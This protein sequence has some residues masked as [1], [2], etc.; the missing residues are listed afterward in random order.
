MGGTS[1][2][3]TAP[4]SVCNI[5]GHPELNRQVNEVIAVKGD[6]VSNCYEAISEGDI[7]LSYAQ[8]RLWFLDQLE[9]GRSTYNIPVAV[10]LQGHL[11]VE[12]LGRALLE[13]IRRHEVLRTHI[14]LRGGRGVQV[15]EAQWSG[16]VEEQD[17]RGLPAVERSQEI[18]RVA[19]EEAERPFDLSRG[20]LLRMRLLYVEEQEHVLLLTMHHIVS[21][22]WSMGL[23]MREVAV[24]YEAYAQGRPSPLPE[25]SIQYADYAVWQREWLQGEVL[26]EQLGYWRKQLAGGGGAGASDGS[27]SSL[28]A[29]PSRR[30]RGGA[31]R[32]AAAGSSEGAEPPG[33][34]VAVHGAADV[35]PVVVVPLQRTDRYRGGHRCGQSDAIGAGGSDWVFRQP[36]GAADGPWRR[37]EC[38]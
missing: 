26:E 4:R 21:D 25:L 33:R 14:E 12:A 38:A 35:L 1:G 34:S 19:S 22:G 7:A 27:C 29:E 20:P 5:T 23:L 8:Q 9:P 36:A 37:A 31:D 24:L 16:G 30:Q 17:L 11:E 3:H 10:R 28:A 18:L 6:A 15:I 32:R 2:A 13:V